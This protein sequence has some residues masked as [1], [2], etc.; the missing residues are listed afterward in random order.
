MRVEGYQNKT[1]NGKTRVSATIA[2][3]DCDLP[4]SEIYYETDDTFANDL[5]CNPN[6]FLLAAIIPAMHHGERRILVDGNVCP[7][8]RNGLMTAM[9]QLR[10]WYGEAGHLP[11]K[12]EA[13]EGFEPMLSCEPQRMALFMS[14]GS[15]ALASLRC[16][17]LDFP[18]HH[19]ESVKDCFFVHGIDLGATEDMEKNYD[20]FNT[21]LESN[22]ALGK[23][24]DFTLIPVYTNISHLGGRYNLF[25]NESHGA[26]LS[27]IAHAFS[28]RISKTLIAA[29][30]SVDDVIPWGS[31]PLLDPNYSSADVSIEHDCIRLSR[32]E[33]LKMVSEW[34]DALHHLR[35]CYNP[36]RRGHVLNCGQC[37]KC[38]RTMTEL[39]VCGKLKQCDTF[40]LNDITP[41]HL[42]TLNAT[43]D[44]KGQAMLYPGNIIY[45][46]DL[47]VPLRQIGRHELVEVI[48]RKLAEYDRN[49][50][51]LE[52]RDWKGI[53]KRLDRRYLN[54]L[55]LKRYQAIKGKLNAS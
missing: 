21:S 43:L 20:H 31:H 24:A 13:K 53:V 12:I 52:E 9:L 30:D 45:W 49:R 10:S 17:R 41:D 34:D 11:V 25:V 50:A 42:Q 26:V 27:S 48:E 23:L 2:W 15:D 54:S 4:K 33:K 28:R 29:S 8:L 46:Q 55:I 5:S 36:C 51:H 22:T 44:G 40:P 3:E 16:N 7:K 19:P 39:L 18:L 37:E 1:A 14:G 38:L 32:Q 47:L 35:C 6:A